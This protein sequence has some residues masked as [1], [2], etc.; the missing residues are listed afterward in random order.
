MVLVKLAIKIGNYNNKQVTT[1]IQFSPENEF[2]P[3]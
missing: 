1:T 2:K 3:T